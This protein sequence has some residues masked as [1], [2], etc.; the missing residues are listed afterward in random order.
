MFLRSIDAE[1]WKS[2]CFYFST[3]PLDCYFWKVGPFL[4]DETKQFTNK[5]IYQSNLGLDSFYFYLLKSNILNWC[6]AIRFEKFFKSHVLFDRNSQLIIN[7]ENGTARKTLKMS[8]LTL[9]FC[10]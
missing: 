3:H 1:Y 9:F 7:K 8:V 10:F 4:W 2:S 5:Q 6:C